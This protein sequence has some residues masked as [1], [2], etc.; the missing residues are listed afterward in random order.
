MIPPIAI[1]WMDEAVKAFP[2]PPHEDI[3]PHEDIRKA[4]GRV[5]FHTQTGILP[6]GREEKTGKDLFDEVFAT[7]KKLG[8]DP[9]APSP[10]VVA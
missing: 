10:V 8:F 7:A 3:Y 6:P 9:W 4:A 1:Y 2:E 5:A